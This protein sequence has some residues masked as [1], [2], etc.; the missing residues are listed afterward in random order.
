LPYFGAITKEVSQLSVIA[1]I[2]MR[3]HPIRYEFFDVFSP[4]ACKVWRLF[5]DDLVD[6]CA[7][8]CPAADVVAVDCQLLHRHV[9]GVV[10]ADL[11]KTDYKNFFPFILLAESSKIKSTYTDQIESDEPE[12]ISIIGDIVLYTPN[13]ETVS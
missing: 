7:L 5:P 2:H 11:L 10:V 4:V 12:F 3:G 9:L 13:M 1:A 6:D 8:D